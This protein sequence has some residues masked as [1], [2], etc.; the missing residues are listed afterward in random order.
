MIVVTHEMGFARTAADRV[1]FMSDGAHRRGEHPRGVLHQPADRPGQ[2]L[3]RQDPQALTREARIHPFEGAGQPARDRRRETCDSSGSRRRSPGSAWHSASAACGD[4]GSDDEG[5]DVEA[6][7][8]AADDFDDGT[9]MKELAEAGEI[10]V[11]VKYD[12][13][14]LGFKGATDDVPSGFDVEI[15]KLLVADL[16]IDPDSDERDLGG[17]DLRQP[18]AV[19]RG[20]RGRPRAGVVLHH[21]RA[22]RRSSARPVPT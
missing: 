14:G 7:E 21:R 8:N 11:G 15:A 22:A 13:P 6:E 9:R 17:D 10:T 5:R 12:Q 1:L 16:G 20:R 2:G 3:P 4:A 19:P 18:R